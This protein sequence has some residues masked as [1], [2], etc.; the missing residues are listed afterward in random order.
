MRKIYYL[1]T[2]STC[3]RIIKELNLDDEGKVEWLCKEPM[4]LKRPIIEAT[5]D[6]VVGFNEDN[7]KEKF[8]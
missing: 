5:N 6:V 4:L 2:C 3:T 7:Y 1:S 8:L